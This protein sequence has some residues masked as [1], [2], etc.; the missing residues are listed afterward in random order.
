MPS[1]IEIKARL[2]DRPAALATAARLS[3]SAPETI[4]Q[5]DVFFV[6]DRARLKLRILA[7]DRGELIRYERT[8][9]AEVRRSQYS[10]A[11][12]SDPQILLEILSATLER[13]GTVK[14]TRTLYMAGQTRIHIDLVEGLGDFLELEVVLR[15]GQSEAEG[16]SIA[17]ALLSEFGIADEQL[18]AE[19]YVDLLSANQSQPS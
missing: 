9:I 1:N 16:K 3:G 18:I 19:A 10:I 15:L 6:T 11:C 12:T 13:A 7:P 5:E 8:N 17:A 4:Q 2:R 14:K